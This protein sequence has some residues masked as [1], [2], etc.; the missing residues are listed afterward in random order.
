MQRARH[1]VAVLCRL[2]GVSRS[3]YYAWRNRPPSERAR[4]DAGLQRSRRSTATQTNYGDPRVY[5]E[6]RATGIRCARKRSLK[7]HAPSRK[8]RGCPRGRRMRT[9]RRISFQQAASDLGSR[10]V[11]AE[12]PNRLWVAALTYV[13]SRE[14]VGALQMTIIRR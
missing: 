13:R 9:T 1:F 2:I 7:A 4:F 5:P 12:E 8:L 6:L 10:N 3:G 14:G 11:S